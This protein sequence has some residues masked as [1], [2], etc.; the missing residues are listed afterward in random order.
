MKTFSLCPLLAILLT[1]DIGF[2]T[3][4]LMPGE[5]EMKPKIGLVSIGSKEGLSNFKANSRLLNILEPLSSEITWIATNCLGDENELPKKVNLVKLYLKE[6][7]EKPFLARLPSLLSYQI[8]MILELRKLK[9]V[10]AFI[11]WY[12]GDIL[13]FLPFL[14]TTLFLKKKTIL[15]IEG[16]SS[17]FWRERS[18][19]GKYKI[20]K[21][22]KV[23]AHS[24]IERVMYSLAH[25]ICPLYEF[26]IERYNL[27]QYQ[28][29]IAV[30][31]SYVDIS[32]Y[33]K[34]KRL[35]ER[36]YQ[37]GYVGRFFAKKGILEFAKSLSLILESK[38]MKA[39]LIG[40]GPLI[41]DMKKIITDNAI[42]DKV[43]LAGWAEN[44]ALVAYL[45]EIELIVVPSYLEGGIPNAALEAMACGTLV[46]AAPANGIPEV[47]KDGET[48]FIMEDNSPDCIARN[49]IRVLNHPDLEK[50]TKNA[51]ELVE[52]EFSYE[53][54]V[55][56]YRE[57]LSNF[58]TE[59]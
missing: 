4:W 6:R 17:V 58:P 9:K 53:A 57:I 39:I 28:H 11:F 52:R 23:V 37:V 31:G 43:E 10:D 24:I 36:I 2:Y 14:F 55:E 29:K 13:L 49:V 54:T 35:T 47:I 32:L 59:S 33:K 1:F 21:A 16:R 15:K 46:L 45:N 56:R 19:K 12:G 20:V 18:A 22:A 44:K 48:G 27:Q 26:M 30:C 3:R 42:H 25:K 38:E 8:R 50:I 34:N 40:D 51:R 7:D 41:S 5:F